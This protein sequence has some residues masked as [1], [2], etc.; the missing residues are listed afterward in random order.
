MSVAEKVWLPRD[1]TGNPTTYA[2]TPWMFVLRDLAEF[3][4][5]I[6]DLADAIYNANRTCRIH[7]G[8]A[9]ATS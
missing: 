2:G 5:T 4:L 3:E 9:S 8:I 1:T 6:D 7:V